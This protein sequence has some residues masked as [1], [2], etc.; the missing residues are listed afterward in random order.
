MKDQVSCLYECRVMHHRLSPLEHRFEHQIFML[1][2]D[3]DELDDLTDQSVLFG[4]NRKRIYELRDSDH[5]AGNGI[6]IKGALMR[7]LA[8]EGIEMA[9]DDRVCL[10]TFPRVAGY[11]FNPVSFYTVQRATGGAV[12]AVAEVGNTF[13]EKKRYLIPPAAQNGRDGFEV[14]VPKHFYVSP[15]SELDVH[16]NFRLN[17]PGE[18]ISFQVDDYE[19]DSCTLRTSLTGERCAMT[20]RKFLWFSLRYPLLTLKVIFLIHWHALRLWL[21]KAP[22]LKKSAHPE[23]QRD[24]IST[25]TQS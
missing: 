3:L 5:L 11:V 18:R 6:S 1:W 14:R 17:L 2:L 9:S 25:R 13:G 7:Y 24:V 10:L 12:C 8:E 20:D 16:F 21:K 4:Y 22:Y 19:A 23:L 15:F